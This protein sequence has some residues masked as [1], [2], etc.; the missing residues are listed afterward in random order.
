M[1][2]PNT[3]SPDIIR[4]MTTDMFT[5]FLAIHLNGPRAGNKSYVYNLK[6]PKGC[7]ATLGGLGFDFIMRNGRAKYRSDLREVAT[8]GGTGAWAEHRPFRMASETAR[9]LERA[10][11][12]LEALAG[13]SGEPPDDANYQN[14]R[15][16]SEDFAPIARG[17]TWCAL[18]CPQWV[19]SVVRFVAYPELNQAAKWTTT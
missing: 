17:R 16:L 12:E 9:D 15:P 8:G 13:S 14:V 7:R 11:E 4:G 6:F 3:S 5:D 1:A 10:K 19:G 18:L 2:T